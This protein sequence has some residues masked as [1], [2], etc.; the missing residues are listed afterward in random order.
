MITFCRWRMRIIIG[1][2]N[3]ESG[4]IQLEKELREHANADMLLYPEGYLNQNVEEA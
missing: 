2:P 4:L 1:Q 3:L